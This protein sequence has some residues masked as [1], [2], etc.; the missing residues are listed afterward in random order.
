MVVSMKKNGRGGVIKR[1]ENGCYVHNEERRWRGSGARENGTCSTTH[2]PRAAE[3]VVDVS[4]VIARERKSIS[5]DVCV[6]RE[7]LHHKH[8]EVAIKS[9]N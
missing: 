6:D 4:R 5:G 3:L 7:R 9:R 2:V 1:L 8:G